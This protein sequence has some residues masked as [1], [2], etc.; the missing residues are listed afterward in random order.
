MNALH[1][2]KRF[3]A[4]QL[5]APRIL[6]LLL[7]AG[8]WGCAPTP[9]QPSHPKTPPAH[10]ARH[11][12]MGASRFGSFN[13]HKRHGLGGWQGNSQTSQHQWLRQIQDG[14]DTTPPAASQPASPG[15]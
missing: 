8:F 15:L 4:P 5:N 7:L 10:T 1:H 3:Y 12:E 14:N 2:P 13:L 6:S 11:S 9:T